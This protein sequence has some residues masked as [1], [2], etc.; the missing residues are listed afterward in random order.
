MYKNMLVFVICFIL[1]FGGGYAAFSSKAAKSGDPGSSSAPAAKSA[2]PDDA[3]TAEK[4]GEATTVAAK[5]SE[6]LMKLNCVSC[7]SVSALGVKGGQVGPDLSK[8][9]VN[10]ESKHGVKV[11]DFLQK[12]T[13]AVMSGVIGS[14]PLTDD[15]LKSV[16]AVLK[17]ASEQS[18]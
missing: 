2:K 5:D 7:H 10:V 1:A 12:P 16:V 15:E 3:K 11:E 18:Q 9:Y 14:K 17:K 8:A 6:V 13:S 4:S